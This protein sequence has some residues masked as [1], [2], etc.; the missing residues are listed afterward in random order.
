MKIN[1][2][3]P[4][5]LSFTLAALLF[6]GACTT[7]NASTSETD[8]VASSPE[9]TETETETATETP[10]AATDVELTSIPLTNVATGESFTLADFS[11]KTVLVKP[12]ATWCGKCK[13]NLQ[14]VKEASAQLGEGDYAVVAISVEDSLPDEDL[15]KYAN[16]EDFD[17]NF[18]VAT[19]EMIRAL[20]AKYGQT[21]LNPSIGS[22]FIISPDGELSE[23]TTG[24][25]DPANLVATLET[26]TN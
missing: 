10:E 25:V 16:T 6:L 9:T 24:K 2:T 18:A 4:L 23:L 11:G 13:A 8:S 26:A 14:G 21:A 3:R 22:R 15:A 1:Y 17:F 20:D 19:P 5:T 12:M 7:N